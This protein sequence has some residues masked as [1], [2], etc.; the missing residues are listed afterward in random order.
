LPKKIYKDSKKYFE[1]K[2]GL[3]IGGPTRLF[4]KK[5][6][7]PLYTVI[8]SLDNVNFN[9]NNF[10]SKLQSGRNYIFNDSKES[11]TQIIHD[12]IDLFSIKDE[13]YEFVLSSH[14]LEHIANPLKALKEWNR[15]IV[16][17]GYL[18]C[19]VPDMRYTYDRKRTLTE[20]KHILQ[21][22][23]NNICEDDSTHFEEVIKLHDFRKDS[24]V[25]SFQEHQSRTLDNFT[26]RIC[27]HHTF[28]EKLLKEML[29]YCQFKVLK[30]QIFKPYHIAIFAQ[31]QV[32]I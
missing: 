29:E 21:D 28:D 12:S 1:N 4:S 30:T 10:W 17:G 32:P 25:S 20:F 3:E 16:K 26:T 23:L 2:R 22:Y 31:K 8:R 11:G 14:V 27:H 18:F 24:T 15:V 19:V 5:G 7:V 9:S 6:A 13:S